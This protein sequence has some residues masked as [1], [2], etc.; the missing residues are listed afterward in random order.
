MEGL[1]HEVSDS[2]G[3]G[4]GKDWAVWFFS[5][6]PTGVF[7]FSS[8]NS[9]LNY[10]SQVLVFFLYLEQDSIFYSLCLIVDRWMLSLKAMVSS[11][12]K[13]TTLSKKCFFTGT[14]LMVQWLRLC[15][16]NARHPGL[17]PGWGTDPTCYN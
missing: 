15:I 3:L 9:E 17:I 13:T 11:A 1:A 16:P 4:D 14:S 2:L 8:P 6:C 12:F 5:S 7:V 10:K